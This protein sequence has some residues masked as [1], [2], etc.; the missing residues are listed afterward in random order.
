MNIYF[1][2]YLCLTSFGF[3]GVVLKHGQEKEH[4][5]F[6]LLLSTVITAWLL[7]NGNFFDQ[8]QA[9]QIVFLAIWTF[10]MGLRFAQKKSYY[11]VGFSALMLIIQIGLFYWAD[12]F[13]F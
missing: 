1:V 4:N 8:I 10:F 5:S 3:G 11:N 6:D 2:I 12:M 9:P 13:K 7:I